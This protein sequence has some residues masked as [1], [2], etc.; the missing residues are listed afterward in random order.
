MILQLTP[1]LHTQKSNT[2]YDRNRVSTVVAVTVIMD[3]CVCWMGMV[4]VEVAV[5]AME[6]AAAAAG[7]CKKY[8]NG[9]TDE[10]HRM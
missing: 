2:A 10:I 4:V 7:I 8:Q 9:S 1:T 3:F 5:V 6:T